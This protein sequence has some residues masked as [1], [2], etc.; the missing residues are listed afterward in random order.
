MWMIVK[1]K[2]LPEG[3]DLPLPAYETDGSAAFDLRA[4]EGGVLGE[5]EQK[6]ISTGFAFE[7]PS[8]HVML[9]AIRSSAARKGLVLGNAIGVL[10][11]DYRGAALLILRSAQG[12]IEW[13]RG[14]RLAQGMIVPVKAVVLVEAESLSETTR[15]AG[16]LGSTG[17]A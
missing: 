4:A 16:G 5:G 8:E 17:V 3:K 2:R 10:D 13:Q 6:L 15:G 1:I 11:S 7:V 9:I 14:D 12:V